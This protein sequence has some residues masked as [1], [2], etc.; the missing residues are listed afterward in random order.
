MKILA[1]AGVLSAWPAFAQPRGELLYANHCIG[2]HTVQV[3]WRDRRLAK[4][5]KGL[6]EQVVRWQAAASLD[7]SQGDITEVARYLNERYYHFPQPGAPSLASRPGMVG[8]R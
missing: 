5:W 3:H 6:R 7:W 4:D 2:C 8:G 1:L